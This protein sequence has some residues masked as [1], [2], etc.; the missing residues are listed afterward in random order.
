MTSTLKYTS[1]SEIDE[2]HAR[3]LRT[4][5][6]GVTRP[7]PYRRKQL[8]QLARLCQENHKALEDALYTDLAKPRLETTM[9]EISMIVGAS[10]SAADKLEEWATPDKP[11]VAEAWRASWDTTV[12]KTPKGVVCIIAPWN[13]PYT[14]SLTALIGAIAAGCTAVVKPSELAPVTA[15]LLAEL[16]PKYLDP[17]SYAIVNGAVEETTQIL[18]L[19]WNHLFFTG[20]IRVGRIV[21]AAAAKFITPFTLELG[22]KSPVFVDV[23]NT[24][25]DIAAK[26]ILWGRQLN[27]GQVCVAPDYVL[28]PRHGQDKLIAALVKAYESFWPEGPF[29]KSSDLGNMVN[30]AHRDRVLELVTRTKGHVVLGGRAEGDRKIEPTIVRDVGLNDSLMEDEIFGPILPIVPVDD[31]EE[32]LRIIH[33]QRA[34]VPLVVYLFSEN[35]GTK[36]KFLNQSESGSLVMNDTFMQLAVHEMP[37][38]GKGES[39]YGGYYGKASFDTFTH[40]RSFVNIPL[41]AEGFFQGRYPPYSKEAYE[42]F[43]NGVNVP[44]PEV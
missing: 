27:T 5:H 12:Y 36:E 17:A 43:A 7:L 40:L 16:F 18:K 8:L 35:E 32:A 41:A 29:A 10:I 33:E 38:G 34:G 23:D 24:D 1:I 11:E 3:L 19:K 28:V 42:F 6:S 15:Q 30:A 20:G 22:G 37:F 44:I 31:V 25:I 13:Y 2:I 9:A 4:F 39:G 26:R 14:L 21:A